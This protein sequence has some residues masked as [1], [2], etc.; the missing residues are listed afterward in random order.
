MRFAILGGE[1]E[2]IA[3]L[4]RPFAARRVL[5]IESVGYYSKLHTKDKVYRTRSAIAQ[6]E[7]NLQPGIFAR[8]HK[9]FLVNLEHVRAVSAASITLS[10][11]AIQPL[12]LGEKY[13]ASFRQTWHRTLE[14][15]VGL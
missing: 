10:E 15:K 4:K 9:G 13:K 3:S 1:P 14:R 5:A 7:A 11:E 6:F 12:P 8:A 2:P